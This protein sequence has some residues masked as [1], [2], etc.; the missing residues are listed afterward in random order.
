VKV[1]KFFG[2]GDRETVFLREL[3]V[4]VLLDA[5]VFTP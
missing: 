5:A 1:E 3:A 2:N 4:D